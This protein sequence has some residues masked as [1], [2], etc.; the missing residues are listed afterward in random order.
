MCLNQL[1]LKFSDRQWEVT[2]ILKWF[3]F[4]CKQT[5]NGEYL[6]EDL[7]TTTLYFEMKYVCLWLAFMPIYAGT[8][9]AITFFN[10]YKWLNFI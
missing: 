10:E 6:L 8:F 7:L 2:I 4:V 9:A 5:I 1:F 3:F